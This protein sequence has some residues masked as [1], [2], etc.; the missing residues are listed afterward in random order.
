V[1]APPQALQ[2]LPAPVVAALLVQNALGARNSARRRYINEGRYV[3]PFVEP[4]AVL[5]RA[6]LQVS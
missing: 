2:Q 3:D 4:A 5:R 1:A 6:Y